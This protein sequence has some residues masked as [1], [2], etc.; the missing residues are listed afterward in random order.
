MATA[1]VPSI[2]TS[3]NSAE[4]PTL[5]YIC[6]YSNEPVTIGKLGEALTEIEDLATGIN[7]I[8]TDYLE[9]TSVTPEGAA[10]LSLINCGVRRIMER[11]CDT[12]PVADATKDGAS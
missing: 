6:S 12:M 9:K 11:V 7:L 2:P 1:T 8:C 3:G 5:S 10:I 4:A